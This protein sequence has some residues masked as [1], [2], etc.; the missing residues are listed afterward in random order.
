MLGFTSTGRL[1]KGGI[2]QSEQVVPGAPHQIR[3]SDLRQE[4]VT[5]AI[6][7]Q[8]ASREPTGCAVQVFP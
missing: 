7:R 3:A 8:I 6:R 2:L 4:R 5:A 1:T